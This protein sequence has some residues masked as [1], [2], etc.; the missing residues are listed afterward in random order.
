LLDA[1]K[2]NLALGRSVMAAT[3]RAK[4]RTELP[5]QPCNAVNARQPPVRM[6]GEVIEVAEQIRQASSSR[7]MNCR[8]A[9]NF[10]LCKK[11]SS[12]VRD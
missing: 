1:M 10:F 4:I 6:V 8:L 11:P 7:K 2:T 9:A 5:S 12:L 3:G